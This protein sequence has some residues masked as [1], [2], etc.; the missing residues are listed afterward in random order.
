VKHYMGVLSDKLTAQLGARA[1]NT[2]GRGG[3]GTE[4]VETRF[5]ILNILDAIWVNAVPSAGPGTP[6]TTASRINIIVA[7]TDPAALDYW[8]SKQILLQV[9]KMKGY[10]GVSSMDPDN[11]ASGSF[12]HWLRLSMEEI[13]R[14]G[15]QATVDES[16]MNVYMANLQSP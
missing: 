4:M 11:T 5:P 8:A 9:A 15:Y 7:S 3:M 12:G 1:H 2:V 14:A 10:S 13:T 16:Y 6:Y